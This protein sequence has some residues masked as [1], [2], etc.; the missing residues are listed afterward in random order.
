[1]ERLEARFSVVLD[2][3][4][5]S[6]IWRRPGVSLG[7]TVALVAALGCAGLHSSIAEPNAWDG[8]GK[9]PV[10][11]GLAQ[12]QKRAL[13]AGLRTSRHTTTA[14]IKLSHDANTAASAPYSKA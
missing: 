6:P 5:I 11:N 12:P 8:R 14:S 10:D 9:E 1:M 7:L 2:D 13:R 4:R 3:A